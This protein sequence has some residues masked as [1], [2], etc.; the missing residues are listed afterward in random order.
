MLIHGHCM[1]GNHDRCPGR[2]RLGFFWLDSVGCGCGC[3][4]KPDPEPG[5]DRW[6][7]LHNHRRIDGFRHERRLV[8][9][10]VRE[11]GEHCGELADY[12]KIEHCGGGVTKATPY[13]ERHFLAESVTA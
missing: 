7:V 8:G 6:E 2:C 12:D 4:Q 3:H 10:C 1:N 5:F 11:N 13:C 9:C